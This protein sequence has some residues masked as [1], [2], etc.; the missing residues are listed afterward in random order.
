MNIP[1]ALRDALERHAGR[2]LTHDECILRITAAVE[3]CIA[4]D[5]A[6]GGQ[7]RAAVEAAAVRSSERNR[8]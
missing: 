1:E 8:A 5:S 3:T 7:F 6:Y 4:Y 2:Q